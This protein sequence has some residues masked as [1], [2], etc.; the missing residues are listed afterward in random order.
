M[1]HAK[2][3][4]AA[5]LVLALLPAT[6]WAAG[7][8]K[9]L[10]GKIL[11]SD[12]TVPAIS[13]EVTFTAY[14][15]TRPGE[16]LTETSTGCGSEYYAPD[17]WCW[18]ECGNFPTPWVAGETCRIDF[19][20]D[21]TSHPGGAESNTLDVVLDATG[22][23]D[24]NVFYLPVELTSFTGEGGAGLAVLRWSTATETDNLGF[25]VWRSSEADGEYAKVNESLMKGAGTTVEP[26][27]YSFTDD[28]L[29]AGTYFYKLED[30]GASGVTQLHGPIQVDV[31]APIPTTYGLSINTPNPVTDRTEIRFQL[32]E[33]AKVKL[34]VYNVAGSLVTTLVDGRLDAGYYRH[35]W[36]AAQVPSGIYFYRLEANDFSSTH[37]MVVLK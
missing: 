21:G 25:W 31:M 15:T 32:P 2:L 20:G 23:Q 1:K 30:V 26:Q 36:S 10:L 16:T 18:V 24:W 33:T 11:Y 34:G 13:G 14:I 29:D 5:A 22:S 27:H 8:P 6:T 7:V 17:Y 35:E 3:L 12:G 4:L 9:Q 28:A 19:V 37:R